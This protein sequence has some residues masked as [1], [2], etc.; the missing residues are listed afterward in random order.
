[1]MSHLECCNSFISRFYLFNF[2][3]CFLKRVNSVFYFLAALQTHWRYSICKIHTKSTLRIFLHEFLFSVSNTF[4]SKNTSL[5]Y[6]VRK[7]SEFE[8]F[9]L[10]VRPNLKKY[11][12][13]FIRRKHKRL[14]RCFGLRKFNF[15]NYGVN[16]FFAYLATRK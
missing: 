12:S 8:L 2:A 9:T 15:F 7:F 16:Y 5:T 4:H 6:F 1:M 3:I 14:Y 13:F 11:F 10:H